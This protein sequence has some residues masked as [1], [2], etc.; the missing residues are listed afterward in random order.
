MLRDPAT[1]RA[2]TVLALAREIAKERAES[3]L[4]YLSFGD[5][6]R[7]WHARALKLLDDVAN[8]ATE[9]GLTSEQ[10]NKEVAHQLC[11]EVLDGLLRLAKKG[12]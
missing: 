3:A 5:G 11:L 4:P 9:L 8:K 1:I 6:P 10:V 7:F 12:E 2:E